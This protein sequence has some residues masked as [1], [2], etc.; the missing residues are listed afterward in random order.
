VIET[1]ADGLIAIVFIDGTTFHLY[2]NSHVVLDR[3][4]FGAD[5]S[6][7]A[8]RL[9]ASKG[10]FGLMAGRIAAAGRFAVETPLSNIRSVPPAVG[11]ASL[12]FMFLLCL[13]D[14]LKASSESETL[15]LVDDGTITYK[16]FEH[17]VFELITKDGQRIIVDDPGQTIILRSTGS[18]VGVEHISNDRAQIVAL[19]D[20][21]QRAYATF[22]Q[23]LQDPFLQ[24]LIKTSSE[25]GSSTLFPNGYNPFPGIDA[26]LFPQIYTPPPTN[27]ATFINNTIVLPPVVP[28]GVTVG[29]TFT[30]RL[31]VNNAQTAPVYL[32]PSNGSHTDNIF[33]NLTVPSNEV[34]TT[35]TISGLPAGET[36]TSGTGNVYNGGG[37]I[38]I[39]GVD[40][41]SGLTLSNFSNTA[42]VL[43]IVATVFGAGGARLTVTTLAL[44]IDAPIVAQPEAV[45]W[46]G[47]SG[48]DWDVAA[49]WSTGVVPIPHQ[50]VFL[51]KVGTVVSSG[52][53]NISSLAVSAGVTL[54][55]TGGSFSIPTS[56]AGKPLAN[57]GIISIGSGATMTVGDAAHA[58]DVV[59][60]N[61][62]QVG[63]G[64]LNLLNVA[65]DNTGATIEVDAASVL[66][67]EAAGID[68]GILTNNGSVVSAGV[69]ALAN[70]ATANGN[71]LEVTGGT[72]TIQN[73]SVANA[74]GTLKVDAGVTL[75]LDG[76]TIS[77][78]TIT[79][80]GII[81]VTGNSTIDGGA[82]LNNGVVN[83]DDGVT[84]TLDNIT[85]TGTSI[86][87]GASTIAATGTFSV[88]VNASTLA[89][90]AQLVLTGGA[91]F[92][93]TGLVGNLDAS[94]VTGA[95]S[96]TTGDI[97]DVTVATGSGANTI[98][99][100][101]LTDGH[102]LTLT[103]SHAATV[104]LT[105]GDLDASGYT[106]TGLLT[107][108]VL[109]N[110]SGADTVSVTTG[111]NATTIT[112]PDAG[113]TVTVH[114]AV[115]GDNS[116]LTLSGAANFTVDGL[117]GDVDASA[118]T[119]TLTVTTGDALGGSIAITAGSGA[120]SIVANG[121]GDVVTITAIAL[122]DNTQLTLTGSA[123]VTVN[124][125]KGDLDASALTGALTVTTGDA[126]DNTIAVTTGSAATSI[127]A[128]GT[129]DAVTVTATAL[130][131]NVQLTLAG[132]ANVVVEGLVGDIV[133][134]ALTGTLTVTASDASDNLIAIAS[135]TGATSITAD[136]ADDTVS[137]TANALDENKLLTVAG[138]AKFIVGGLT[139]DLDASALTGTLTVTVNNAGDNAVS[140]ATGSAA[141]TVTGTSPGDVITVDAA[142][143]A[144]DTLLTLSGPAD[145]TVT[146]LK[147]DLDAS[148]VSGAL[149]VTTADVADVTVATGSGANTIDATALT[150]GH[151]LTLTGSHAAT[152]KLTS[153]DLD[154][155]GYTGT[156][157]LTVNVLTN[158]SGA[159]TVSVTTGSNATTI[160]AA[161]AGDTVTVNAVALADNTLL[162]LSGAGN[163]VVT[164]LMGNLDASA[165]TG[166]L[167]VTT[168]NA[169][170]NTIAITAGSGATAITANGTSDAVMVTASTAVAL[171][172]TGT[173]AFAVA[174][175]GFAVSV[176]A[177]AVDPAGTLTLTG[178]SNYTVTGLTADLIATGV[179]GTLTVTTADNVDDDA[180]AITTG[181]NTTTITGTTG[182]TPDT[183]TVHAAALGN[184]RLLT[185]QGGDNFVVDG[186]FGD[187]DASTAA[188][189]LT[190][191]T[192]DN[193][194]DDAITI[195]TG[196]NTTSI[197][198]STAGD[199]VTVNAAALADN[200]L[201]TLSGAG[202][203][204]VTGLV[205]D[206]EASN[207]TG[208]L[209]VTTA[210]NSGD[211]TIVI[212]TGSGAT[213]IDSGTAATDT[214]TVHAAA[215]ADDTLLTLSGQA[216][217]TV[218]GLIGDL[219]AG[220]ATAPLTALT[221]DLT[222]TT[223]SVAGLSVTTGSGVNTIHAEALTDNQ[224]LTLLGSTAAAVFLSAGNLAAGTYT[225]NITITGGAGS[226]TI[227]TGT[228][229]DVITGGAGAD[230]LTGGLGGDEFFIKAT[231]DL[232]G[233]TIDG[234]LEQNT[235]DTLR[236]T[237]AGTYDLSTAAVTN[238]D[239][240]LLQSDTGGFN[241]TLTDAQLSTADF[242]MDG[243]SGDLRISSTVATTFGST[244]D[245]SA[246]SATYHINFTAN[247]NLNGNN[248]IIGGA[249]AD[250]IV[251]GAGSDTITGGAGADSLTGG[252]GND[253]FVFT[254][255]TD[256]LVSAFDTI[257]DFVSGTDQFSI[258]HTIALADLTTG[259][260]QAGTGDL[261]ADL[262][263]VFAGANLASNGAAEVTITSGADAGTYAVFGDA[264][265]GYNAA[266]DA[267]V[268]LSNAATLQVS[269]FV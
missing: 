216:A 106:G 116:L 144:D 212:T 48:G 264:T 182:A 196:A 190:V 29:A 124:G 218:D 39:A 263:A 147:G 219:D 120:T 232:A 69:S 83:V 178:G 200:M 24:R 143:L 103:G 243:V 204:V 11:V 267:V 257:T 127:T 226:N 210:D 260:T 5:V 223:G 244:V 13:I 233:D 173:A 155:S 136:G 201:L 27:G 34:L 161:D 126:P 84:L 115:M 23:G 59:N 214:I 183:V 179:T 148:A 251:S 22:V 94:A 131:E 121:T 266:T 37:S 125:L 118:L 32:G 175:G 247:N 156:G 14:D 12:G 157:L 96:V 66:N 33:L 193:A 142:L 238:I 82:S 189:T 119:G 46:T 44:T 203:F 197:V 177:T 246:L 109:T 154:A 8:A 239:R 195:T 130:A 174:G 241:L 191:T 151:V 72:L 194:V 35:V 65:V 45:H 188:G 252:G 159:D 4:N 163:F 28:G 240:I 73:G 6:L 51:N 184:N 107:V 77:G 36:M 74:G 227:T 152:V 192:A 67:L 242:N 71:L 26:S 75:E 68:G 259:L 97:A 105:S 245:A 58:G 165:L 236:F 52:T 258:G 167:S 206:I 91:A 168:G 86:V 43:T 114:A 248:V 41:I 141:S 160:A 140:I 89:D 268:K 134:S 2:A 199:T 57:A 133:T 93:V 254:N 234:T 129:G 137:V 135:G 3:F 185:L 255:L 117:V 53:V 112:A 149:N 171:T 30:A 81:H 225:G 61:T 181:T 153:G 208:A 265:A 18:G 7:H 205:G 47:P 102:V 10:K 132:G 100:T 85:I 9:R 162:T 269:D 231:G 220:N 1:G 104:K 25:A 55:I 123:A 202:N 138:S 145:F 187:L 146:G 49:N 63:G 169:P 213:V 90:N 98:D 158:G 76:A 79:D 176:D 198:G 20:V 253:A 111:S 31:P 215:L 249:G 78:G 229:D 209:K 17:G 256:S 211:D 172:L 42:A 40:F 16:D 139:A 95:L 113:D 38:T 166:T 224:V 164:G 261:A 250:V 50:D 262:A 186:L 221:G 19:E 64:T 21:Y 92:V 170:D 222:V 230:T 108:N 207:L 180:I 150:D 217:F 237:A 101:A 99:A 15:W 110:G 87:P 70:V 228:G 128:N 56:A 122:A 62:L 60:S 88:Q 235:T 80:N 54:N